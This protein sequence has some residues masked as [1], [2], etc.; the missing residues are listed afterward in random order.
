MLAWVT[1]ARRACTDAMGACLIG[2]WC[3]TGSAK[4]FI[5]SDHQARQLAHEP[6]HGILTA[7]PT[8][9][10]QRRNPGLPACTGLHCTV[11]ICP[12]PLLR[13][14]STGGASA[15][16]SRPQCAGSMESNMSRQ[17]RCTP[18]L[19]S[20][21]PGAPRCRQL[22]SQRMHA[23]HV[24]LRCNSAASTAPVCRARCA[25]VLCMS[26]TLCRVGSITAPAI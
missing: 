5:P 16:G 1:K 6:P 18:R 3:V 26:W 9:T 20:S 13:R 14:T 12:V 2:P 11:Q 22:R 19:F 21:R 7:A 10:P 8:L 15:A 23:L 17:P 4:V 24:T 25:Q